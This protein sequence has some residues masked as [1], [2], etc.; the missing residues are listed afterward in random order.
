MSL[1]LSNVERYQQLFLD[2]PQGDWIERLVKVDGNNFILTTTSSQAYRLSIKSSAGMLSPVVAPL[3]RPGGMF[4]RAS[5]LIFGAKHDRFG[6]RS[7]T[8]N[9][10]DVYL[11]AQKSVQKWSL[12]SDGQKV[13]YTLGWNRCITDSG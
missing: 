1:T 9:G 11:M 5:P 7:V 4:G 8:S 3:M 10:A 13:C 2:L 12:T 6:I